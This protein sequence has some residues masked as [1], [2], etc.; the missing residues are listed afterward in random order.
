MRKII[1]AALL[2]VLLTA[3]ITLAVAEPAAADIRDCPIGTGCVWT[4]PNATGAMTVLPFSSSGGTGHCNFMIRSVGSVWATYG[5]PVKGI[6]IFTS[7][8]CTG[9]GTYTPVG[10]LNPY[11]GGFPMKSYI[12][13]HQ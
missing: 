3:G 10:Q 9:Q 4:G 12:L 1:K 11:L 5:A 2:S 7:Y 13:L 6:S 8:D